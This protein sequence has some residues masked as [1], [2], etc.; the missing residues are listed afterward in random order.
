MRA[1]ATCPDCGYQCIGSH[2]DPDEAA[3]AAVAGVQAHQ[4]LVHGVPMT[5][6]RFIT[7]LR[8]GEVQH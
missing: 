8:V 2:R 4:D 7:G 3:K 5:P 1:L 6:D